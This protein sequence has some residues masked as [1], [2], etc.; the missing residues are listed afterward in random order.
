MSKNPIKFRFTEKY[1]LRKYNIELC[2][3]IFSVDEIDQLIHL[4]NQML[5]RFFCKD[6]Q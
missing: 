3:L 1:F 2:S 4:Y 5:R 6:D